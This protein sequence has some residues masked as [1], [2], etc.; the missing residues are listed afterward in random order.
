MRPISGVVIAVNPTCIR[1]ESGLRV[2]TTHNGFKYGQQVNVLFDFTT[3][4]VKAI[5]PYIPNEELLEMD[6]SPPSEPAETGDFEDIGE[7]GALLPEGDWIDG[8]TLDLV[9]S[10]SSCDEDPE[11]EG[12]LSH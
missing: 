2:N 6:I 11:G 10:N 9:I 8:E 3:Q 7:E 12:E 1:L 4:T 5:H